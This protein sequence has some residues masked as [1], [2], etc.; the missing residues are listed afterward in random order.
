M[1]VNDMIGSNVELEDEM[2]E[3]GSKRHD[4]DYHGAGGWNGRS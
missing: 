3:H 2:E 4:R 1:G